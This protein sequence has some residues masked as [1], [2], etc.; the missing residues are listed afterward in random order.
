MSVFRSYF[1]KNSTLI[2][3]NETNNSQNPV[4]E[5]AYGTPNAFVTRFIFDID[6]QPLVE[7]IQ[8]GLIN[9]DTIQSHVLKMTNTIR[10]RPDLIGGKFSDGFTQRTSSFDLELFNVTEDWDEG[11]GYDFVYDDEAYVGVPKG[12]ANWYDRKTDVLWTEEGA[13]I[14]GSSEIL[15]T[16]R[17]EKGN[18]DIY[19]DITDYVNE[20]LNILLT[21]GTGTTSY[22]LGLK[23]TDDLEE[24]ETTLRQA[25]GFH[26]RK[27]NTFYEPH[28]L[29]TY[30][31]SIEDD[32]NYFFL[33]KDNELYLY[34]NVGGN[35]QSVT[36]NSVTIK[37][38][39]GKEYTTI[40]GDSIENVSL[41]VYKITLNID[42]DDYPDAVI[43]TDTWNITQNGKTKDVEQ[44]FYL[45]S[46][47]NY[48]N[49]YLF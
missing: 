11:N 26:A 41:G 14:S 15:A 36:V 21:G 24:L 32:R 9:P 46:Q 6:L 18:E 5:I 7:R 42:S 27:T 3:N 19:I 29:T 12:Q 45:I 17:F 38:Y 37:D 44:E 33:D 28:I 2:E 10:Y 34:A 48:Y 31:N 23:Y 25:V 30:D 13:Y 8:Q 47:D 22:G 1:S 16:Q 35:P 40:S 43:F 39:L 49:F 4:T 20:R